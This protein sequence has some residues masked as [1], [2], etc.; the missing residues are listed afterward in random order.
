MENGVDK[1]RQRPVPPPGP[2]PLH[3]HGGA[4]HWGND[5]ECPAAVP[6]I[7]GDVANAPQRMDPLGS[8][9]G[10]VREMI[11]ELTASDL[12]HEI[13]DCLGPTSKPSLNRND[14]SR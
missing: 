3:T 5:G 8:L 1:E 13:Q 4:I 6:F 2:I 9:F 7:G 14:P 12:D 11:N 10:S